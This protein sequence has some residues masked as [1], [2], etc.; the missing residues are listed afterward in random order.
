MTAC[1]VV[2]FT[3]GATAPGLAG[4]GK[5]TCWRRTWITK[6]LKL[7]PSARAKA[8]NRRALWGFR[9]RRRCSAG[10]GERCECQRLW[11]TGILRVGRLRLCGPRSSVRVHAGSCR[12][13]PAP[14]LQISGTTAARDCR[15]R[16]V[17]VS[18]NGSCVMGVSIRA[19][20]PPLRVERAAVQRRAIDFVGQT[21]ILARL[22]QQ[23]LHRATVLKREFSVCSR[24]EA[25]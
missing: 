16:C 21:A 15:V 17:S 14:S 2:A 7:R 8:S 4:S 1:L 25:D 23:N 3:G 10:P 12:P 22:L 13:E 19:S 20:M 24:D 9:W 6:L 11:R 18:G 5:P